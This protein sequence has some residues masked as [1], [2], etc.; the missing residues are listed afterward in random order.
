MLLESDRSKSGQ[1]IQH[2]CPAQQIGSPPIIDICVS[3]HVHTFIVLS[4]W[5]DRLE[6]RLDWGRP[7]DIIIVYNSIASELEQCTN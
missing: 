6:R 7:T 5:P 2:L 3:V 4:L 1:Y